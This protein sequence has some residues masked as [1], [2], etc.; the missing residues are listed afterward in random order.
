MARVAL[1]FDNVM[2]CVFG[3]ST[4]TV[5]EA[6][7]F[8]SSAD[9]AVTVITVPSAVSAGIVNVPLEIVYALSSASFALQF[10]VP[11]IPVASNTGLE[12]G[13]AFPFVTPFFAVT[14]TFVTGVDGLLGVVGLLGVSG[15]VGVIGVSTSSSL[16]IVPGLFAVIVSILPVPVIVVPV[17]EELESMVST[18]AFCLTSISAFA[19][20][21]NVIFSTFAPFSTV[22]PALA[23]SFT[24][25][26]STLAPF[27]IVTFVLLL[28]FN[29]ISLTSPDATIFSISAFSSTVTEEP[30]FASTFPTLV[31]SEIT[32]GACD[33]TV[34]IS[35]P[36]IFAA[37][38]AINLL[39]F[40]GTYVLITT[41]VFT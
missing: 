3:A 14:V 32:I 8:S 30:S 31:P 33:S 16:F 10:I 35:K 29:V 27:V 2:L 37:T 25:I 11:S 28:P 22:T 18:V 6:A 40:L 36:T 9:V 4:V 26:L 23:V 1:V 21:F 7:S 34:S 13:F 12:P 5:V 20:S 17:A 38:T 15:F 39:I 24:V 41:C 19:L